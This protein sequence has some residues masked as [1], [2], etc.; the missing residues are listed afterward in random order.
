MPGLSKRTGHRY[1]EALSGHDTECGIANDVDRR[2]V[3]GRR[4]RSAG[5]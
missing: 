5:G 2:R 3:E 4:G 1:S